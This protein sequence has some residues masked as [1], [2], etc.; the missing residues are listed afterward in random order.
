MLDAQVHFN[1]VKDALPG[2][3]ALRQQALTAASALGLPTR[4]LENWHYTDLRMLLKNTTTSTPPSDIDFTALQ[5]SR[6]CFADGAMRG[7]THGVLSAL[8]A[9]TDMQLTAFKSSY[10]PQTDGDAMKLFNAALATDGLDAQFV[11]TPDQPVIIETSGDVVQ[12]LSH[13][14]SLAAGAKVTL[15]DDNRATGYNNI[16]WVLTLAE[17]AELTIIRLQ[18]AGQH[19]GQSHITLARN[20]RFTEIALISGDAL[21]R[22]A[23]YIELQQAGA[24]AHLHSAVLGYG[25]AHT[26]FTYVIAHQAADTRSLTTTH[27]ALSDSARGVFQGKVV[28]ARDAQHVDAQMQA[29]AML[30]SQTAEMDA[31]P[32]LEIYADDVACAH[33]TAIGGIDADAL[34][35]LR[36]RGLDEKQARRLLIAGFIEQVLTHCQDA[37]LIESLRTHLDEKIDILLEARG[38][39]YEC[40]A[41]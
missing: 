40:H 17:G 38:A 18:Q 3:M 10:H 14:V 27:Q 19:I 15:I 1:R 31:R 5:A 37:K 23:S 16:V 9:T 11:K 22:C 6:I 28:V 2:D 41:S 12:H 33:G 36:T 24:E 30:L 21:A 8:P 32:E 7:S 13:Y 25:K 34:F 39:N 35:F 26:D 4:R 29:R 20:A